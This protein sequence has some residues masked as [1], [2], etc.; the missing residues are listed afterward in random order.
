MADL[1]G[2]PLT[3]CAYRIKSMPI[4]RCL[5]SSTTDPDEDNDSETITT[6][7]LSPEDSNNESQKWVITPGSAP[8]TY[9]FRCLGSGKFLSFDNG[10]RHDYVTGGYRGALSFDV[11]ALH[12]TSTATTLWKIE[13]TGGC[14][15]L[16]PHGQTQHCVD[17]DESYAPPIAELNTKD[18][19]RGQQRWFLEPVAATKQPT[20]D[21]ANDFQ[22][23]FFGL[24]AQKAK[25]LG[26]YDIIIIGTGIGGGVLAGDLFDTNS[27]LGGGAKSILV[28][29]R[30]NLIFHSHCLN[31]AR[32]S[33]LAKDRGQQNDSFFATF[34]EDYTFTDD[35]PKDDWKGGPMYCLGGRS[36]VWG[37]F[38]PRIHDTT[39]LSHFPRAVRD[40]LTSEYYE[41]AEK[42]MNLSLP[43][44]KPVHQHLLERLNMD[45]GREFSQSKLKANIQ[46]QWGRVASE[47]RDERNYDFA[48]GAYSTIDKLLEIAMSKPPGMEEHENFKI[49][50]GAEARQLLWAD[51]EVVK[52]VKVRTARGEEVDIKVKPST[53]RVILC[54]GSVASP[55]ILLRSG[56]PLKTAQMG[57]CRLT[58]HDILYRAKSFRYKNP[59]HR[60]EV[61]SM[62]LQTYVE[63]GDDD[64]LLA[65]LSLDASS[66]LPRGKSF[67]EDL[68][69]LIMVFITKTSL[70]SQCT[71]NLDH[72]GEPRVKIV[73]ARDDRRRQ[74][75]RK[76][77]RL[78]KATM[79]TIEDVLQVEFVDQSGD[80]EEFKYLELGGVA[81]ELGTIPMEQPSNRGS[82][83]QSNYSVD[84]NLKLRGRKGVYV[85][86]L[87]V[88]P[89]SPEANP[90]LTLAALSL[91]L[92][93]TLLPRLPVGKPK[94]DVLH[95]VNHTGQKIK[96][97]I[98][99]RGGI[100]EDTAEDVTLEPGDGKWWRREK[101]TSEAV[102]VYK[103]NPNEQEGEFL[104]VPQLF[105]GI[106]GEILSID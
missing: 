102:F 5:E 93:R 80:S 92:S 82:K 83:A 84:E 4:N 57:G 96:V 62:K 19:F 30:G 94:D 2:R 38:A 34:K 45:A 37:L 87:S 51:G 10:Q 101:G 89:Y 73:R 66:F 97:W 75:E 79:E 33:G 63:T 55:A 61:G 36:A 23:K 59:D 8:G 100:E 31:T 20:W 35:T 76:M 78:T 54:A 60:R 71:I 18:D 12:E 29:E 24:T 22:H 64:V 86:D 21:G 17:F 42:L 9:T 13:T 11:A 88:F 77:K 46:W 99:N 49:L 81:H 15:R 47:F 67:N 98:S 7:K 85:C 1:Y 74:D 91:R 26:P 105:F 72:D 44:T 6:M 25:Q 52:G 14:C 27:K 58:D 104:L 43:E 53:G 70:E 32:P 65:N 41:K 50:L 39:L 90:T 68:P 95:I 56:V 16:L 48:E 28:I 106:P 103:T 40:A 69:R 3:D